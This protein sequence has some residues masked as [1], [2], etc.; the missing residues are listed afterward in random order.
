MSE[1]P[2]KSL[3][4]AMMEQA[5]HWVDGGGTLPLPEKAGPFTLATG[6]T[7][8]ADLRKG[9]TLNVAHIAVTP[10]TGHRL[11]GLGIR[12]GVA[13][14]VLRNAGKGPLLVAVGGTRVGLCRSIAKSITG[15]SA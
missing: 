14:T 15:Q 4:Q 11:T 9:Q 12:K 8:L 2:V 1:A 7:A 3:R 5:D 6:G 13:L 10:D